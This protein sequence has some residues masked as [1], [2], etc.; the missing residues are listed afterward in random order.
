[1]R[2]TLA[3]NSDFFTRDSCCGMDYYSL[4]I[5]KVTRLGAIS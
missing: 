1:M 4:T 2:L 3:F 5:N